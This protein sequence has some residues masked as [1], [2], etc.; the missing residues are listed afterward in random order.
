M[1]EEEAKKLADEAAKQNIDFKKELERVQL[2]PKSEKEKAERALHFNAQ[3]LVELG[4]DPADVLKLKK[5]EK[6]D[7]VSSVVKREFAERD[8]QALSRSDDELKLILWYVDNKKVSVEEAHL[9]ANK[10]RFIRSI[11]EARRA[12]VNFAKPDEGGRKIGN[13]IEVPAR[14]P[15]DVKVLERRG[16]RFNPKTKSYQGKFYEEYYDSA[17]KTW[18]SRKL[19][20]Q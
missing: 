9:L 11:T 7:D 17:E 14:S 5:D 1:A 16:M 18:K 19:I 20:K 4:G 6:P 15:E 10:G 8:A 3:R 13:D 2:E 12:N